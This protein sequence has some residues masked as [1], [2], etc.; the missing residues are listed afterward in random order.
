MTYK[1]Y[2]A[3]M[4]DLTKELQDYTHLSWGEASKSSGTT[5]TYLKA[6]SGSGERLIYYKLS[7]Y[8]GIDIDGHECINE[9]VAC[10]LMRILKIPHLE[11]K[12][13]HANVEIDGKVYETWLNAS[14]NF[15]K[16]GERKLALGTYYALYKN[17]FEEPLDFCIRM[18][19]EKDIKRIFLVDYLVANR[20]RHS[21]NIE[22]LVDQNGRA[23]LAPI[24]DTGF[25]LV[26][27]YGRNVEMIKIF[28]PLRSVATTNFVGTRN[29]EENLKLALPIRLRKKLVEEDKKIILEG[30]DEALPKPCLE[31]I[32]EIIWARWRRFEEIRSGK[33]VK[34]EAF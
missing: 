32:W 25:S 28:E 29:L 5:G 11:Y 33:G 20:D 17:E 9:L 4:N 30:L 26:A 10:R 3:I 18:G 23:R 6:R 24:F 34:N 2:N 16:K 31:K 15:R 8:T 7:R 13:I 1:S 12:L 14:K 27:P 22:V 21:S 19:W